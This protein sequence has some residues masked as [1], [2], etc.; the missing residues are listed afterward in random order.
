MS[1]AKHAFFDFINV[2]T[3]A[4]KSQFLKYAAL[5]SKKEDS[6][7]LKLFKASQ[8]MD[9]YNE[10]KAM[11]TAA[12]TSRNA[13]AKG[14]MQ[15][16]EQIQRFLRYVEGKKSKTEKS[17][18]IQLQET[19]TDILILHERGAVEL[20]A[21]QLQEAIKLARQ[22]HLSNELLSLL[23][24]QKTYLRQGYQNKSSD[25]MARV[26]EEINL[27]LQKLQLENAI[28]RRYDQIFMREQKLEAYT[29]KQLLLTNIH[30]FEEQNIQFADLTLKAFMAYYFIKAKYYKLIENQPELVAAQ[31]KQMI[32]FLE[33]DPALKAEHQERYLNIYYNYY[34]NLI[35]AGLLNATTFQEALHKLKTIKPKTSKIKH[36][37]TQHLCYY[38]L[39]YYYVTDNYQDTIALHQD[40]EM[41]LIAPEQYCL[42]FNR[43]LML[44]YHLAA[45]YYHKF[46][47]ESDEEALG[48]AVDLANSIDA[49]K[50]TDN[51]TDT[52]LK[53]KLLLANIAYFQDDEVFFEKH[54]NAI[55]YLC[56]DEE[57]E[58]SFALGKD[59]LF[60][61][62]NARKAPFAARKSYFQKLLLNIQ[63]KEITHYREFVNYIEAYVKLKF[64]YK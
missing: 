61:L 62:N 12:Y 47:Q 51:K 38:R 17:I 9:D 4:E 55:R 56:R 32:D 16:L 20:A 18:S 24:L 57:L 35:R 50:A 42:S 31:W 5:E 45:A 1:S 23:Q 27:L 19:I 30:Y 3:K 22:Q 54:Y 11:R 28:I 60:V 63:S 8:Q 33:Q 21:Q 49:I 25:D 15:L 34:A 48:Q 36:K 26:N 46:L 52:H 59:I 37:I 40:I 2:L 6:K 13:F 41:L 10:L 29:R 43:M 44:Q 64:S 58:A 53:T 7:Q 14:R 39:Q